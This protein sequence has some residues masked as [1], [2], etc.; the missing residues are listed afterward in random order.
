[1]PAQGKAI[2]RAQRPGEQGPGAP[3]C[4]RMTLCVRLGA[5]RV[6]L[7]TP[8][9][10]RPPPRS[11]VLSLLPKLLCP[12]IPDSFQKSPAADEMQWYLSSQRVATAVPGTQ[13][14]LVGTARA[15]SLSSSGLSKAWHWRAGG[16]GGL[17]LRRGEGRR[18]EARGGERRPRA[19]QLGAGG[20]EGLEGPHLAQVIQEARLL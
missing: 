9:L 11:P 6:Q 10:Y 19:L 7:S 2:P 8:P 5:P 1:M 16:Q 14:L 20:Q 18:G 12:Q 13:S 3:G 15:A 4:Q 17:C